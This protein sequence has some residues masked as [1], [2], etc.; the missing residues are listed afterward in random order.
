MEVLR[1]EWYLVELARRVAGIIYNELFRR[2]QVMA[3]ALPS[4]Q[5]SK[6]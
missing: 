1:S 6:Y 2:R 4:M 3:C 5:N